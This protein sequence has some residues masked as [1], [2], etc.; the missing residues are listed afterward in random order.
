MEGRTDAI[1]FASLRYIGKSRISCAI[2][3][4]YGLTRIYTVCFL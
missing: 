4:I 2:F 1:H 3:L